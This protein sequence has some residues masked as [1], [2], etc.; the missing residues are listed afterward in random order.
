MSA[1]IRTFQVDGKCYKHVMN[2]AIDAVE[3][4][5]ENDA[6]LLVFGADAKVRTPAGRMGDFHIEPIDG[7]LRWIYYD[8]HHQTCLVLGPD[9]RT[10]EVE[11]SRRYLRADNLPLPLL[12]LPSAPAGNH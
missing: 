8:L 1:T 10:A 9:L 6:I 11:I 2:T 7:A 4:H 3:L 5:D 12:D